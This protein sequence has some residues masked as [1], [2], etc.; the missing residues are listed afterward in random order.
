MSTYYYLCCDQHKE[1]LATATTATGNYY[2][3]S[4]ELIGPFTLAHRFCALYVI[5]EHEKQFDTYVQREPKN[6]QAMI[7]KHKATCP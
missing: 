1:I 2:A 3:N 6:S 7:A 4:G 5:S